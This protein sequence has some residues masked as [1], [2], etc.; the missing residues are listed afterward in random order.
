[1][2]LSTFSQAVTSLKVEVDSVQTIEEV[3]DFVNTR[4]LVD[5]SGIPT[6]TS[7][8]NGSATLQNQSSSCTSTVV[9]SDLALD[10]KSNCASVRCE[11]HIPSE[12]IANCVATLL[13]IQVSFE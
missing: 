2:L 5:D 10:S 7:Q 9:N 3:I 11:L 1:M 8:L 12:L 6:Q 13:M 4:L